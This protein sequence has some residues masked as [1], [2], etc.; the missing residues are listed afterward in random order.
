MTKIPFDFTPI[1][2]ETESA[3]FT[4][5]ENYLKNGS[6]PPADPVTAIFLT[7]GVVRDIYKTTFKNTN[8]IRKQQV[9]LG[10]LGLFTLILA[11]IFYF[12]HPSEITALLSGR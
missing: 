3:V 12:T 8:A 9:Q 2:D 7:L 5:I 10:L 4:A 11:A 6:K 1:D